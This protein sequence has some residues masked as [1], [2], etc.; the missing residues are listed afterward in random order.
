MRIRPSITP[1][2]LVIAAALYVLLFLNLPFVSGLASAVEPSSIADIAFI[3]V[4]LI[5][6]L[7]LY[8]LALTIVAL[9]YALKPVIVFVVLLSAATAYFMHEYGIVIDVNMI[10]NVFETQRAE[11]ADLITP[12]LVGGL[13]AF[14]VLPPVFVATVPIAWPPMRTLVRQNLKRGVAV[15]II[16]AFLIALFFADFSSFFREQRALLQKLSPGNTIN[17]VYKYAVLQSARPRGPLTSIGLDAHKSSVAVVGARPTVVVL[18]IG[19]T[20]RSNRFSL[21]GYGRATNPKLSQIDDL[22]SFSNV[23]SCGTDTAQ[24]VPCIFSGLGRAS[25]STEAAA[26]REDLL[27]VV[28]RVGFDVLWRENQTG[29]KGVCDR[30]PTDALT[31]RADPA[32]CADGE[33]HDEILL[34]QL[35]SKLAAMKSGGVVVLH[36]MGSHGPAYYKRYPQGFGVFQ[37]TCETSQFSHCTLDEISNSYDNTIVYTDHVLAELIKA[38]RVV[39]DNGVDTA[40]IYASDH[41]ESLGE[42]G[43]FLHGMPYSMAPREQT[44]VPMLMW[45]SEAYRR[46]RSIDLRCVRGL[47][48]REYSHDNIFHTVLGMLSIDT[49]VRD[50]SLDMLAP[51]RQ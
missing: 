39:A 13:L 38:L 34:K 37:P 31:H 27:D 23:S 32:F 26:G 25:F 1:A 35:P 30:V 22:I 49:K 7:C 50:P 43:L 11:V 10:R 15:S 18:V 28:R 46:A 21:N 44:H 16:A 8:V 47:K 6:V 36:M 48:D 17:A 41:G 45:M 9:P 3:T 51:C 4:T 29:C 33:C 20:A 14:G 19:E 40:M 5:V 42:K 24:S 12:K 2:Q